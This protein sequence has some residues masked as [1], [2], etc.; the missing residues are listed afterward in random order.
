MK[1]LYLVRHAKSSWASPN[2]DDF[3]R[4]L[5]ERGSADA[6]RM[7]SL[8]NQR[9]VAPTLMISSPAIRALTT[10]RLFAETMHYEQ[11]QIILERKLYHASE[12]T[13]LSVLST[14][15]NNEESVMLF[16]HNPGIT[17]F[18]NALLKI[19]IDNIP[20]CGIVGALLNI[21]SWK[22]ISFGCGQMEFF[23][24]PKMAL[25]NH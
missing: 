9:E 23:I 2:V 8:L 11:S 25:L 17:E 4:P 10:C 13:L 5:N 22:E 19:S 14:I 1:K 3:D 21:R 24:Y 15:D 7:A 12:E 6:P 16:A 20:T 18:A